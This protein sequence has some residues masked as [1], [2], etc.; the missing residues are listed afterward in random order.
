MKKIKISVFFA[1]LLC[2]SIQ[3][4][5]AV[6]PE[7]STGSI[8]NYVNTSI[9]AAT[10]VPNIGF[11]LYQLE[12]STKDF[13]VNVS[14]SYHVYNAK[15][16]V[17]ASEVGQGWSLFTSGIIT[18]EVI[19]D[20]DE[21]KNW[22]DINEEQADTFYY[23]IP[24]HSGKF[25]IYKDAV[26]GILTVY[27]LTGEKIK[28]NF[29]KDSSNTKFIINSFTITDDR[30][31][32]YLFQEYNIGVAKVVAFI[33][34]K[35]SFVLTQIKDPNG[36]EI[37]NYS[38]DK[39]I[40]YMGTS[41]TKKYQYCKINTVYTAKGKLKFDYTY[42][43][44]YDNNN[45][46]LENDPYT[47]NT[48][49][50][51]DN[52]DRII[53]RHKFFYENNG[54]VLDATQSRKMLSKVQKLDKNLVA[55]E[56]TVLEYD[57]Q[58]SD[59]QYGYYSDEYGNFLCEQNQI[60]NPKKY[61]LGLLKK[62]IFPTKGYVV[63]DFE[64][65]TVYTDKS[66]PD[67]A[68]THPDDYE[69]SY[70]DETGVA[71]DTHNSRTYQFQVTESRPLYIKL[72]LELDYEETDTHGN[73]ILFKTDIRNASNTIVNPS[74]TQCSPA[75]QYN[76]A[77]G[78]Y[79]ISIPKGG[80][81]GMFSIYQQKTVAAP[82]KNEDPI[83]TGARLKRVQSFNADGTL[84]KTKKYEYSS[85]NG[86]LGSSGV[87]FF[88]D[89][90][91][92]YDLHKGFILY[93]NVKETEVAGS[94]NNGYIRYYFKSPNDYLLPNNPS[95]FPYYNLTSG[96][97]MEKKEI[98]NSQDQLKESSDYEYQFQEIAGVPD[99]YANN[100]TTK[101]SWLQYAK[102]TH[103]SY[104]GQGLYQSVKETTY[105]PDN[106]QEILSKST[107]ADGDITEVITKYA[108]NMGD[109]R[110]V[111]NNIISVPLQIETR[112][113]GSVISTA[114]TKYSSSSHFYPTSLETTDLAQV[115]ETPITFDIYD[116]KGNLVQ[117][118]DKVGNSIVTLWGYHKTL[119]I[120]QIVGAKYNDIASLPVVLAA[121]AASDADADNPVNG[122]DLLSALQNLR[123]DAAMHQYQF[124]VTAYDPLIGIT[125]SISSNGI[126]RIYEYDNSGKLYRVKNADGQVIEENQ[127]NYKH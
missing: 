58:G 21:T 26:T 111:N 43:S 71:F 20:I 56:E 41:S 75:S 49:S 32:Q 70:Y 123:L 19:S 36:N 39:R 52:S 64:A 97:V 51:T 83:K 11:P 53:S 69:I 60:V 112:S 89:S 9:S 115:S 77:P 78:T 119:P 29:E 13:P 6:L 15:S 1:A 88:N 3:A 122:D 73:I 108:M 87:V 2:S 126:M 96:G 90:N 104:L 98:Y 82:Y 18:R 28:I 107:A 109:M 92:T 117:F 106:F 25:K 118:T 57:V 8:T 67:Y 55:D 44:F 45:E 30:G 127:Y 125:N 10:G 37:V 68:A 61:T 54:F 100:G 72:F 4:Q 23:T 99:T 121:I 79:T 124:S 66:A 7:P 94:E 120:A 86:P 105:S 65:N 33:N 35:T 110:L 101:P 24:G 85:F 16:D 22:T 95:Y 76:L 50:L 47:L 103:R 81:K 34:Y 59:T 27:N 114:T 46:S 38:Y 84:V 91:L 31:F 113:N 5:N 74:N 80:G 48:L 14:L 40:K 93:K 42:D 102:E 116:D 63:Y 62:I 17:P 12:S